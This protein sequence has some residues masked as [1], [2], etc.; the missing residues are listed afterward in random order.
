MLSW[1][2]LAEEMGY[3]KAFSF[4]QDKLSCHCQI[5]SHWRTA[6]Q[7]ALVLY[8]DICW[9]AGHAQSV[10]FNQWGESPPATGGAY[11]AQLC[12]PET[13]SCST[14]TFRISPPCAAPTCLR[15]AHLPATLYIDILRLSFC[16]NYGYKLS[17]LLS[18]TRS[19]NSFLSLS[20]FGFHMELSSRFPASTA[21]ELSQNIP[22][23]MLLCILLTR[24]PAAHRFLLLFSHTNQ[25]NKEWF[26]VFMDNSI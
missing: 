7:N 19:R 16:W 6:P 10:A 9:P 12:K 11:Y 8:G 25:T 3:C 2:V 15:P 18:C 20:L 21:L 23:T 22:N 26:Y 13:D 14:T 1:A 5:Y 4:S 17:L 24:I